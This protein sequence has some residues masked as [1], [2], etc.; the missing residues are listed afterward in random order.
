M[1]ATRPSTLQDRMQA[2][3]ADA[4]TDWPSGDPI[5]ATCHRPDCPRYWRIQDRLDRERAARGATM[6]VVTWEE[7]PW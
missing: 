3:H 7:E 6:P 2:V 4:Y 5:C 1:T